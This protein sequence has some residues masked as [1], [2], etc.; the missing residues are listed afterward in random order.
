MYQ[1]LPIGTHQPGLVVILIDQSTSMADPYEGNVPKHEFAALA[2]NRCIYEIMNSCRAGEVVKDRCHL[3]VIGYGETTQVLVGG[4]PS[5]LGKQ[6]KG[7]MNVKK[8]VSDGA[9]GL[10]EIEQRL[11]IWV[12][13]AANDGTP[14]DKGFILAAELIGAWIREN[15]NNFPP[16]VINITDGEPNQPDAAMAAAERLMALETTDGKVLLLNAHLPDGGGPEIKLPSDNGALPDQFSR[17]LFQISSSLPPPM[18]AAA[19]AAGFAPN[20]GAR[21]FVMNAGAETL[22]KL[23]VFGSAYAR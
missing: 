7:T 9:G 20:P 1:K 16:V 23:L 8:R 18:M 14:M 19:K 6:V 11:P 13:P 5:E 3:G 22:T 15:P 10:V 17:L 4:R 2:V 21:G 12:E